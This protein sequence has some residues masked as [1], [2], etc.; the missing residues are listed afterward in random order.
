M[1]PY[2]SETQ[3]QKFHE[4]RLSLPSQYLKLQFHLQSR[5]YKSERAKEY[6]SHGLGRRLGTLIRAID[7]V[8]TILPPEREDIPERDEVID[9]TIAIQSFVLNV[10]GCLDNLA[11]IWVYENDVKAKDGGEQKTF[12][13]FWPARRANPE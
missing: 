6:A 5:T 2:F 3:I 12:K 4:A 8:F 7:R 1:P 10:F 11:W 9:A 13:S